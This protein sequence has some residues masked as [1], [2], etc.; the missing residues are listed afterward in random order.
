MNMSSHHRVIL[1]T[2]ANRG[3]GFA[4]VH[5]LAI[6]LPSSTLL[7]GCR[8]IANGEAAISDLRSKGITS[9]IVSV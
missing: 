1:I 6:A 9:T 4:V 3:I 7:L 2:G 8:D 5:S